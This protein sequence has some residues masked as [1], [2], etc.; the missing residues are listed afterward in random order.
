MHSED[1]LDALLSSHGKNGRIQADQPAA[2]GLNGHDEN[3][4]LQPLLDAADRLAELA[5]VEPSSDFTD[6]LETRIFAQAALLEAQNRAESMLASAPT[7]PP[8]QDMA[9]L[10]RDDAPTIP[11]SAWEA[12]YDEEAT[13]ADIVPLPL[14]RPNGAT[15]RGQ[16]RWTRLLGPALAAALLLALGTATFTAAAAAG[17]GTPLYGL[18]RWEQGVQASM[19]GS[20]ADRTRL[21]LAYAQDALT[22]LNAAA[23]RHETGAAYDDALATFRDEMSAATTNLDSTP[24][25][26]DHNALAAQLAQVS[27]QGRADLHTA[28]A[29]LPWSER[30]ATTTV[31]AGIGDDVLHVTQVNM[32][33]S[34]HGQHLWQ[35][36]VTGSGFQQG[37][38]LLVNGQPAGT[39]TSVTATIL[40]AQMPGDDSAPLP[41]SIGVANPDTTAALTSNISSHEQEDEGTPSPQQT[42]G[43]DDHGGGGHGGDDGGGAN[44]GG[45]SG[46]GSSSPGSS[47]VSGGSGR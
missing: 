36:T 11:G 1:R 3:D 6:R 38:L 20:A 43:G 16:T 22:A 23:A 31:L 15:P 17:P 27:A 4:G 10:V 25:S 24:A 26:S 14:R 30:V 33:Y 28:L 44:H 8:E 19:A 41:G 39:V 37:A 29:V 18:H 40:V 42:P 34:G 21:H 12:P 47:G 13:E 5:S 45:S 46:S 32:V 7:L 9:A 2:N 35:I